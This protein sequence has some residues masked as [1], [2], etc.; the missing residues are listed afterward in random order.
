[1]LGGAAEV[2]SFVYGP[3]AGI[4]NVT[5]QVIDGVVVMML[6]GARAAVAT[7]ANAKAGEFEN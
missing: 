4:M 3:T 1:M 7:K 5:Q 6:F 2:E